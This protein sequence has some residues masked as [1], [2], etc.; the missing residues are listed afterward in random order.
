M[1]RAMLI[2]LFAGLAILASLTGCDTHKL[3]GDDLDRLNQVNADVAANYDQFGRL[4][5]RLEQTQSR[6][7]HYLEARLALSTTRPDAAPVV[8][9]QLEAEENRSGVIRDNLRDQLAFLQSQAEKS[10]ALALTLRIYIE[11][12]KGVIDLLG[13]RIGAKAARP[14]GANQ[15]TTAADIEPLLALP[16][17]GVGG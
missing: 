3:A 8:L 16:A 11:G 1:M 17:R 15:P 2:P 10:Q 4:M 6:R 7:M 13:A 14:A 9:D 5:L 12:S